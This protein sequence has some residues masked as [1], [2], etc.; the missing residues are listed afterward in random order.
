M[1]T[2]LMDGAEPSDWNSTLLDAN[3]F[4]VCGEWE[5]SSVIFFLSQSIAVLSSY[6]TV[7][8]SAAF[9]YTVMQSNLTF[10]ILSTSTIFPEKRNWISHC[11]HE[12]G[13]Q[14][15]LYVFSEDFF[16]CYHQH[17]SNS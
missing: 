1:V 15:R 3:C 10:C 6:K 17:F 14:T 11:R 4:R 16:P 8:H 7:I 9:R 5:Q 12:Q 13:M 2:T